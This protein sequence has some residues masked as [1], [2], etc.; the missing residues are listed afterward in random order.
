MIVYMQRHIL[1]YKLLYCAYPVGGVSSLYVMDKLVNV[2]LVLRSAV[3]LRAIG[4]DMSFFA[5]AVADDGFKCR[6]A[7]FRY[8]VIISVVISGPF[9]LAITVQAMQKQV[10]D[11]INVTT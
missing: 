8:F 9:V 5:T 2:P 1:S 4:A 6:E 3:T 10:D 7:C 11:A